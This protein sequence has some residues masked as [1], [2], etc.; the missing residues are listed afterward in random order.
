MYFSTGL[1]QDDSY[2]LIYFQAYSLRFFLFCL[3][4][5]RIAIY[6][7]SS[8]SF[9]SSSSI[10]FLPEHGVSLSLS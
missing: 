7:T 1:E 10:L 2:S 3:Q 6:S 8:Y 4:D 9:S 5:T